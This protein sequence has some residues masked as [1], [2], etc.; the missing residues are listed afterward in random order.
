MFILIQTSY[1]YLFQFFSFQLR[2][3]R[4]FYSKFFFYVM[5]FKVM[6]VQREIRRKKTYMLI[7]QQLLMPWIQ[8]IIFHQIKLFCM[9]NQLGQFHQL[10]C[11]S[12]TSYIISL[13]HRN[14]PGL[15]IF[16]YRSSK[17]KYQHCW[18]DPSFATYVRLNVF[19]KYVIVIE[20]SNGKIVA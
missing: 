3:L 15:E 11:S 9:D 20:I 2:L 1:L 18:I 5:R 4:Y 8:G 19:F 14:W 16:T 12:V 10:V 7:L 17:R 6:G 13:F